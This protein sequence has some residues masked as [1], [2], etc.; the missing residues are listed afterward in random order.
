[1]VHLTVALIGLVLAVTAAHAADNYPTKPV[2]FIIPF[3]PGGSADFFARM[4]LPDLVDALGQPVVAD[5]RG[6]AGGTIGTEIGSR[7]APDGHTLVLITSNATVNVS[8]YPNW[9]VNPARDFRPVSLLGSAPNMIAVN[10]TLPVKNVNELI[11]LAKSRPGQVRYASGGSGSTPH[12]AAELFKTMANIELLHVPYKGTGPALI[13]V[14]SGESS[15][16]FPPASVALPHAKSGK[17]RA[18]AISSAT[19]FEAAGDLPTVAES[20]VPGYEASQ[21]YG[22]VVPLGTPTPIV[23]RLNRDLVKIVSSPEFKARML[24]QAT[25]VS[26]TTP[27]VLAARVKSEIVKWAKVIRLAKVRLE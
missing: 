11:A 5:N 20:G 26:G 19:R 24:A 9:G 15:V 4:L 23:S 16:V 13:G 25:M 18:L 1:V 2:R 8:L 14:F 27:D 17:L 6:G 21:W 3:P 7:A 10:P 12:L 22:V